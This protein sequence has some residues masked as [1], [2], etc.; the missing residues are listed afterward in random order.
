M[1]GNKNVKKTGSLAVALIL[2]AFGLFLVCGSQPPQISADGGEWNDDSA[3]AEDDLAE[4]LDED[5][6]NS[7]FALND[8][9]LD[10][11][12]ENF[13]MGDVSDDEMGDILALLDGED[14]GVDQGLENDDD[15]FAFLDESDFDDS[16][17]A[18]DLATVDDYTRQP[19]SS[20]ETDQFEGVLTND[21]YTTMETESSQLS[22]ALD[23]KAVEAESLKTELDDYD[24]QI[25]TLEL[26][27]GDYV[28]S[29]DLANATP[30]APVI[31]PVTSSK[32]TTYA[33]SKTSN[34]TVST[35]SKRSTK[36]YNTKYNDA[37]D[38]FYA[39]RY[40]SAATEF[41]R[42]L[43]SNVKHNLS[44][45]CQYFMGECYMAMRNY[46][47][48]ILE[49]E[50]VFSFDSREKADDAQFK[51]GISFLESGNRKMA[52]SEFDNLLDFY[53]DSELSRK[54]RTHLQQL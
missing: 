17:S 51:I 30:E 36:G 48:A 41:E 38:T 27:G 50:K 4:F 13:E 25:A 21:D 24:E 42:L 15:L 46:T 49:Y 34:S 52:R 37:L 2:V 53:S 1:S 44:D 9:D 39:G 43:F 31:A 28:S 5:T 45:N 3:F 33:K 6:E 19:G 22:A 11:G 10:F 32:T 20:E 29:T 8:S 14:G 54:A 47:R 18:V 26:Q 23:K 12:D 35:A 16:K 7:D 40:T